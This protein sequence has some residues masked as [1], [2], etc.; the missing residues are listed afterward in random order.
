[1]APRSSYNSQFHDDWAWSLAIRGSTEEEI[2]QAMGISRRTLIRWMEN[3]P[4]FK[5]SIESGNKSADAHV[6]KTL[7]QKALGYDYEEE[8]KIVN[9]DKNGNPKPVKIIKIKKHIP[10]DTMAIMYWLNNRHKNTGE[11]AQSQ[12]IKMQ[13]DKGVDLS[14]FSDE[15]LRSLTRAGDEKNEDGS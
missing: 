13:F 3:Y 7:Y 8:E 10:A 15:E 14:H 6:E 1:M 4:S 9:V 5:E 11:W 12:N 2:A